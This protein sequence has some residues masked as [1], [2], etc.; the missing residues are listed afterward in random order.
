MFFFYNVDDSSS[1]IYF[2]NNCSYILNADRGPTLSM[3]LHLHIYSN[4]IHP[5]ILKTVLITVF[6]FTDAETERYR[7]IS[8]RSDSLLKLLSFHFLF[9]FDNVLLV[10]SLSR[11]W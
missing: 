4:V 11:V 10:T 1:S 9:L 2:N 5:A 3:T 7:T 8:G 6:L